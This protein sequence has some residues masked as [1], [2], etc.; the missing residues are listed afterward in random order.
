M[1]AFCP[2]LA[3]ASDSGEKSWMAWTCVGGSSPRGDMGEGGS[4]RLWDASDMLDIE[5]VCWRCRAYIDGPASDKRPAMM[6][7][8]E[9]EASSSRRVR[10]DV[11]ASDIVG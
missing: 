10:R 11:L 7:E 5:E 4:A 1:F 6:G 8:K 3:V 2:T 9:S